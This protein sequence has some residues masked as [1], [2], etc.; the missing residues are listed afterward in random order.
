MYE[1][2]TK[3]VARHMR[4]KYE[5]SEKRE[6]GRMERHTISVTSVVFESPVIWTGNWTGLD[7]KNRPV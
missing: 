5:T 3:D 7:Q 2:S 1:K 4:M 6:S